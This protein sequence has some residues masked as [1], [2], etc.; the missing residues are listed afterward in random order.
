MGR[1]VT[2]FSNIHMPLVEHFKVIMME[3]TFDGLNHKHNKCKYKKLIKNIHIEN[4]DQK[5]FKRLI[6]NHHAT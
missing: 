4:I 6:P 5:A 1:N 3:F 2:F